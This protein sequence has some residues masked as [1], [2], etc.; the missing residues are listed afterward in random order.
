MTR[1]HF[2]LLALLPVLL[3]AAWHFL[4]PAR[5]LRAAQSRLLTAISKKDA[6]ACAK[7]VHPDYTDN[8]NFTAADWPALLAD[9][10]T[11]SPIL[12][13]IA[14]G[15]DY[16]AD[17]GVVDT[18]LQVKSVGGPASE[19]IQGQSA[20]LKETTRFIWK[21]DAWRPWS[22]RLVS[23]QNPALEIPDDYRPGRY[24]SASSLP[25]LSGL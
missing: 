13:I 1:R 15:P 18:A 12:E 9:L 6:A 21:R 14:V 25:D 20:E 2:F 16:E 4:S 17:N 5:Q 8:W 3:L 7:L 22:W 23:V 10:R 24:S 19:F 11:L